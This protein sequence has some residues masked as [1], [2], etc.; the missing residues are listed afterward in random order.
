MTPSPRS[1]LEQIWNAYDLDHDGVITPTDMVALVRGYLEA[2]RQQLPSTLRQLVATITK[3]FL[4][5]K[6]VAL[7]PARLG[8]G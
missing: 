8:G 5:G 4:S 7:P 2:M 3:F 6:D 1:N